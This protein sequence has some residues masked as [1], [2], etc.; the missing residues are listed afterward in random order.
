[1]TYGDVKSVSPALERYTKGVLL[2]GLWKRP[3]TV[4]SR[5]QHRQLGFPYRAAGFER[6][7]YTIALFSLTF[8][9]RDNRNQSFATAVQ[10]TQLKAN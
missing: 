5:S 8:Q 7:R 1:M 2:D 4:P 10:A 9:S 3:E 6:G